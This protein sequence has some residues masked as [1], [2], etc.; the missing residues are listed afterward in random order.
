MAKVA[1]ISLG[2]TYSYTNQG[3][4]NVNTGTLMRVRVIMRGKERKEKYN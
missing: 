3:K 1:T 2:L 4:R